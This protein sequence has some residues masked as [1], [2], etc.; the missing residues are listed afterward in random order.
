MK[1]AVLLFTPS[2]ARLNVE[3]ASTPSEIA[4]GLSFRRDLAAD[5]GMLFIMPGEKAWR[6][7]MKDCL[8][9]LDL[10]FAN[11]QGIVV[12]T[13][14]QVPRPPPLVTWGVDEPSQWVIE[15][16]AGW[17]RSVGVKVGSRVFTESGGFG[18]G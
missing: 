18:N 9:S 3:V 7:W 14:E 17:V 16:R 11:A 2:N 5:A 15:A 1:R 12:G 10:V 6:M 4:Q 13:I 8:F